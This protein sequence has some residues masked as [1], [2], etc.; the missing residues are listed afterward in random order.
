M[1]K[2]KLKDRVG[3]KE[4]CRTIHI[5]KLN[6]ASVDTNAIADCP[7]IFP[8]LSDGVRIEV[9]VVPEC[10]DGTTVIHNQVIIEAVT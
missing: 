2:S 5:S 3:G 10:F 1:I 6:F 9:T 7:K 4:Y 8:V